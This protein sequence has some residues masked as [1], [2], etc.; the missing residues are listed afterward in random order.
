[1]QTPANQIHQD[2]LATEKRL[3]QLKQSAAQLASPSTEDDP[4]HDWLNGG[5]EI[6][7]FLGWSVKR[8]YHTHRQGKFRGAVVKLGRRTMI[9]SRRRLRGLHELLAAES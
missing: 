8:V 5:E 1:M 2:I 4:E 7:A 6:A 9:G 3:A